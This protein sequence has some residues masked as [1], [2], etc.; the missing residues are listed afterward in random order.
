M[1]STQ[2]VIPVL[3]EYV[4]LNNQIS[5]QKYAEIALY[6]VQVAAGY[7]GVKASKAELQQLCDEIDETK[8][9]GLF[10]GY[11]FGEGTTVK[12]FVC[13]CSEEAQP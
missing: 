7:G 2:E 6:A 8:L 5:L 13:K 3:G 4:V 11:I 9:N 12:D 1:A 10:I